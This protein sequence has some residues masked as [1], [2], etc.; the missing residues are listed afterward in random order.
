MEL[1]DRLHIA[2]FA[3][4]RGIV[5]LAAIENHISSAI[6]FFLLLNFTMN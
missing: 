2:A 3:Y 1:R 4:E 6:S 5:Q